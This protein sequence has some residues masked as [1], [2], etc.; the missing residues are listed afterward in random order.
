MKKEEEEKKKKK[1]RNKQKRRKEIKKEKK[2]GTGRQ[3]WIISRKVPIFVYFG[4]ILICVSIMAVDL[5]MDSKNW[6]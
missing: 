1:K 3:R 4:K 2:K 6:V 5:N